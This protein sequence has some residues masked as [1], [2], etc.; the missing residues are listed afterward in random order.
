MKVYHADRLGSV[1]WETGGGQ[2]ILASYVYEGFG[3]TVG[4]NDGVGSKLPSL[5]GLS[6]LTHNDP[7]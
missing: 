7:L 2:N 6:I 4:Q 5:A 1:R 3:K